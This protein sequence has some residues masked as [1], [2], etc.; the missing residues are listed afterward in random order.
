M[1][2]DQ[3]KIDPPPQQQDQPGREGPMTPEPA[4]EAERYRGS[5]KLE[6]K[7]ALVTG[8]DSGIGRAVSITFAKEGADVAVIYLEEHEDAKKTKQLVEAAGRRCLPIAGDVAEAA[9]C[10]EAVEKAVA[11]FGK[12]DILVN[13]AAVQFPKES[14]LEISDEQL[15]RTF[16]VNL[17]SMFYLT[18]AALPHLKEG[19][20]IINSSSVTAF[21]GSPGLIDYAST[22]GGSSPLPARWPRTWPTRGSASTPLRR[23]LSGRPSSPRPLKATRS[24]SSARTRPWAAPANPTR[25]RPATSSWPHKTART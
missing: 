14:L 18:K 19:S 25:S 13:N 1:G 4:S 21:R 15:E 24:P 9:F 17:F 7:V 10:R 16:R 11:H 3:R 22:K 2:Q 5:G 8:G 6:G 12:L 23:A 20:A